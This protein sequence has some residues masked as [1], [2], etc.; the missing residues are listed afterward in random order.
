MAQSTITDR[1]QTTI[2]SVV[3][4]ALKLKPRQRISYQ[5][6][7]D[8]TAVMRPIPQ[9]DGLFGSVK[10]G[11]PVANIREEKEAARAAIAIEASRE[12]LE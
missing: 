9:I 6:R 10:L 11:R 1:F 7:P 3:R 2:P 5:V 4:K 8:G 12:G